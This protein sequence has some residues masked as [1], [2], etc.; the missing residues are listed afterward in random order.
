M[1]E[2]KNLTPAAPEK[3]IT[4][5][6]ARFDFSPQ[7]LTEATNLAKILADSDLV[8]AS[9]KGKP[10][11]VLVAM[12]YGADL[13][14]SGFQAVQNIAII[15][16]KPVIYGDLG[17]ALLLREGC[18]IEELDTPA[19]RIQG[20]AIC[21]IT[22]P[23]GRTTERT[24]SL[25]DAKTAKL[26]GKA[27]P[28]ADYPHRQMAWR[29]F[30]FAARDL[31]ADLL[32]G[33]NGREEVEDY[34]PMRQVIQIPAPRLPEP[35]PQEATPTAKEEPLLLPEPPPRAS[36]VVTIHEIL[37]MKKKGSS[38]IESYRVNGKEKGESFVVS[39][40]EE[41]LITLAKHYKGSGKPARI[42][43]EFVDG[44]AY[45]IAIE[46]ADAGNS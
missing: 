21:R 12:S 26:W 4:L 37:G 36:S 31:C 7:N 18:T 11:N 40:G 30:W 28:W 8:P 39:K 19:I 25:E 6:R 10:G 34:V 9:F 43:Y 2:N 27:G 3:K 15:S 46:D 14:L 20:K 23:D 24:F 13:G 29:A 42:N 5:G 1:N 44:Y 16:G 22:R 32:K 41:H 35:T 17:R 38:E 33:I 45:V